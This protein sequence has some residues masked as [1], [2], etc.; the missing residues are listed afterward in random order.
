MFFT[1]SRSNLERRVFP[2]L[3]AGFTALGLAVPVW[4]DTTAPGG[5]TEREAHTLSSA[6]YDSTLRV[7][8]TIDV[9]RQ[10][11][12][13]LDIRQD[14]K[15]GFKAIL[16]KMGDGR[17][18]V[19]FAGTVPTSDA[20]ADLK[21]DAVQA[22]G[23]LPRQYEQAS[24]FVAEVKRLWGK[25]GKADRIRVTG[26]SLGGGLANYASAMN[27]V[28]GVGFNSA[29]LGRTA[30]LNIEA[31]DRMRAT[32]SFVHYNNVE[33]VSLSLGS[34]LGTIAFHSNPFLANH[35]N[36]VEF[37][38]L[39]LGS[40]LGTIAFHSNPFLANPFTWRS[41]MEFFVGHLL[42]R[43]DRTQPFI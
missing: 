17:I 22:L 20:G 25:Y 11:A 8:S 42:D 24:K 5:L 39:S 19:S 38:S 28:P 43:I 31:A 41:G 26:H 34:Q 40:R 12:T 10:R 30:V 36:N 32:E 29:P 3:L 35:Y 18:A 37:V 4:A 23:G 14:S 6:A 2:L 33:F 7:R 27:D 16:V 1:R 9:G 13:V 15:T 21:A